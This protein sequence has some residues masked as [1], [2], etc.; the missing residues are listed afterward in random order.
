MMTKRRDRS[1]EKGFALIYLAVTLT[2]LLLFTGLA[3]DSGRAYV[4]KAQL[5]KA[6]D[7]AALGAA[8]MLN[9]GDPRGEAVKIFKQNFPAGF[10]NTNP[11]DDPT[12]AGNFF[13]LQTINATGV[14]VVTVTASIDMPTSFM[15][16]G[17]INK[18]T[19]TSTGEATRRMVDLS[20]ILD[21]SGSIASKWGAV[22][23]ASRAFINSFDQNHDR[24]SLLT[25]SDGG[26]VLYAMPSSRGFA[27][28]TVV[29]AVPQNL[30]GGSTAM[31]EG[32]YRGWDEMRSVPR[33]QQSGL[34]VIVLF[35]DGASNS[36]PGFYDSATVAKGLR[37]YDF[38]KHNPDPDGQTWNN[39]AVAGLFDTEAGTASPSPFVQGAAG[40]TTWNNTCAMGDVGKAC[41]TNST[42]TV[43][44]LPVGTQSA[45]THHRSAG[46]PTSF[47]LKSSTLT[48]N[49]VP[50]DQVRPLRN[51]NAG[52]NRYPAEIFNINNAA[53]NLVEIIANAVRSD[54]S[55]DYPIRIYT[56]GMGELVRYDLGTTRELSE[57]I[58]K[59]IANDKTSPDRNANQLEGK[60]YFA[61][62][63]ADVAPAFQALQN[64]IIRLTK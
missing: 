37:T 59:R 55:G 3:V 38:P 21:V 11:G 28:S 33:G 46:I 56:I 15:R 34:R 25:Y 52:N 6:V 51:F 47:P 16:L 2:C 39:P 44:W 40:T 61:Q 41:L 43:L 13:N 1:G 42:P 5:S 45:H 48:V 26:K 57:D 50:Q 29:N 8:R 58:L 4:V 10:M 31:V 23:D 62:T 14:N 63:E 49:H 30:P 27:K 64:Q 12:S 22:R 54:N 35:T 17:R 36:V 53:R 24:I 32:L 18:V 60:Y 9:T 20:L 19:V 7:G